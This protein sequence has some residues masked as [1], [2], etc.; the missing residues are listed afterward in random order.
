[1]KI[2]RLLSAVLAVL[3]IM[4]TFVFVSGA[5]GRVHINNNFESM[6]AFTQQFI[7]GAFYVDGGLLFKTSGRGGPTA[8]YRW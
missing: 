8:D 2:R 6:D 7:A 1:M 3:M 5:A 4:S